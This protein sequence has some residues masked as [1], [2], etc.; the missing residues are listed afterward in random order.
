MG[1]PEPQ[2]APVLT[3]GMLDTRGVVQTDPLIGGAPLPQKLVSA[4]CSEPSN[5]STAVCPWGTPPHPTPAQASTWWGCGTC[6]GQS[7]PC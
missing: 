2:L 6:R 7:Q 5:L 1:C 3:K 4:L